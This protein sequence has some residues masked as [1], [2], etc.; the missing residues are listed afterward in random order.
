MA[1]PGTKDRLS[2]GNPPLPCAQRLP[3]TVAAD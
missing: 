3:F 1:M 2:A